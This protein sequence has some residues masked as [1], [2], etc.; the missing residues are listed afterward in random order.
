MASAKP[1][2]DNKATVSTPASVHLDAAVFGALVQLPAF[3]KVE[4]E[5][6]FAVADA[7]FTLRKV[8]DST[9]K[10]YYVLS[11]VDASTLRKLLSF[12]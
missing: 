6:W 8:T 10:Y 3:D 5:T 9:T 2:E 4:V 11:K 12:I 1:S 7:N